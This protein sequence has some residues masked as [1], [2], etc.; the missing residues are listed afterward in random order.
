LLFAICLA[1]AATGIKAQPIFPDD[2]E[3]YG[4]DI[5]P[6]VDILINPD[7]LTWLY[8]NPDSDLE[9]HAVFMF[10]NG[11]MKDT[12]ENVGFRLRGNTSRYSAKKSFKISFNT[13]ENGGKYKGLEKMNLNGEHNDPTI[14]RSKVC[15]DLLRSFDLPAPRS[16]HVRVYING[17]YFGLYINVE[18]IDEKFVKS[19]FG[20]MDGNLYKCLW[21]A[22]L[23]YLGS[24]P[25]LYKFEGG[26]RRT[27]DLIT[28]KAEDDYSDIA[29]FIG[30][31]NNTPLNDLPCQ[32][33][34]VF[35]VQDY[36]KLMA[37]DVI[38]ANWDGYIY[39]QNNF[40][41]YHNTKSDRF[42]YIPYDLDNTFGVDWMSVQWSQRDVYNWSTGERPLYT[43]ILQIQKYRDQYS[44]YLKQFSDFMGSSVYF[45]YIFTI[46][47]KIYPYVVNDP[48]YP[49]DYGYSVDDF[50]NSYI[51][52]LGNHIPVG[53][54]EYITQRCTSLQ[55]QLVLNDIYPVVKY[56]NSN[57]MGVNQPVSFNVYAYD[58]GTN[59]Q[60]KL[61]YT[62]NSVLP[63][64]TQPMFDDGNHGD[65]LA[66]DHNYGVTLDGFSSSATISYTIQATDNLGKVTE[67]PCEAET[68]IIPPAYVSGL[69]INEFMAS[70]TSTI[71]DE[72]GDYDDW[73]EIYNG[74]T[75][76]VWLGDK[77]LTD[78]LNNPGK[79]Q[80][81]D[82]TL[83]ENGFLLV[84]ADEDGNQGPLHAS[85][86]L[87]AGG[88]EIG[89]FD[90]EASGFAPIDTYVFGPQTTD[91]S[92]GRNPDGGSEWK[93]Y[94]FPTPGIS[95]LLSSIDDDFVP[96]NGLKVY[97]NPASGEYV[98]FNKHVNCFIYNDMGRLVLDKVGV[99]QIS[100]KSL[101]KGFYFVK[102]SEGEIVKLMV[103]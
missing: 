28:N 89:I 15:W 61:A 46:R 72:N 1:L 95:N 23:T 45:P 79:W 76:P 90:N 21:P 92:E 19:R 60:V 8:Q 37:F 43:R 88:E 9:F 26:G 24:N 58:D 11:N 4:D 47:D 67:F 62:I 13:F 99:S 5:I 103:Y 83:P 97:P 102:T 75:S 10:D 22:D 86:K 53:L 48:F 35:N 100:I 52:G 78:N 91:V 71:A 17:D 66:G 68:L 63:V 7:T 55:T 56:L 49:L 38:T 40:Y 16:N 59:L 77:Y 94:Q 41:L 51:T 36:L 98:H 27:Y 93:F 6:R 34:A 2:G 69:Y 44:K 50:T 20:N 29:N 85:F 70:N 87:S 42:E 3:I 14:A 57:H 30:I 65:G 101:S 73:I 81:P 54:T 84:W 39:N 12:V 31:L 80:F 32:L 74:G 96:G 18:H 33:E 64:T 82:V 25:D